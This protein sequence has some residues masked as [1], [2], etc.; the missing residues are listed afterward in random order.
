MRVLVVERGMLERRAVGKARLAHVQADARVALA[1]VPVAPV[2]LDLAEP[3][4]QL[5]ERRLDLLQAQHVGLLAVDPV[6]HLRR[7]ARMPLTFPLAS[8]IVRAFLLRGECLR[9]GALLGVL[10]LLALAP[11]T[12]PTPPAPYHTR[13]RRRPVSRPPPSP[14][15]TTSASAPT[16]K[17]NGSSSTANP[18]G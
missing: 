15:M 16:L 12:V 8:L 18:T 3:H 13:G 10:A 5:V 11:L 7:R 14:V 6:L 9:A 2:A 4:G 17:S 1:A